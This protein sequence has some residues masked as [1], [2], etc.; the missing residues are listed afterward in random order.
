MFQIKVY[1]RTNTT[2]KKTISPKDVLS[3][4]SF[5][6]NTDGWLWEQVIELAYP[7]TDTTFNF[8][9]IVRVTMYNENNK[10][11]IQIYMWY[12]TKIWRK[13]TTTRQTIVLTCLWVASLLTE[14]FINKT[15]TWL[16]ADQA[17]KDVIDSYNASYWT[18]FSYTAWSID[19]WP[20]LWTGSISWNYLSVLKNLTTRSGYYMFVDW[21]WVVWFKQKPTSATH[22][23][24]NKKDVEWIDIKEDLEWVVNSAKFWDVNYNTSTYEDS[25]S[26]ALYGRKYADWQ[27]Q[28]NWQTYL[29]NYTEQ[30]VLSNK[31]PKKETTIIVNR[32]Y[33]IESI[34]PWDTIKIRNFEYSFDN[35]KI[36]KVWYTPDKVVLYLD[37][38]ISFWWLVA[39]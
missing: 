9:D 5:S 29:D 2:L 13:Q 11:W 8:W 20:S 36:I 17:F 39:N 33:N 22:F 25:A 31:D 10:N 3:D 32:Q 35:V 24:T 16:T 27:K 4:I 34:K 30:Y 28:I 26:V 7:I 23:L 1:D 15:T 19:V 6:L 38:Y 12:V 18:I 21:Q 14:Q 37:R